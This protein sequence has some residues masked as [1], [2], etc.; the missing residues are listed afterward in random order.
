MIRFNCPNCSQKFKVPEDRAGKKGKCPKCKNSILIPDSQIVADLLVPGPAADIQKAPE[1]SPY[2]LTFL[3]TPQKAETKTEVPEPYADPDTAEQD[4]S[5]LLLGYGRS[6]AEPPAERKYPW[7]IDIL[8][9]PVSVSSLTII[10]ITVVLPLLLHLLASFLRIFT[11]TFP[12]GAVFLVL[13]QITRFLAGLVLF[14]YIWWYLCEC[15]TDSATGGLRAPE[16]A[17]KTPGF[18]EL[19]FATLRIVGCILFFLAPAVFYLGYFRRYDTTLWVLYGCG[20]FFFPMGLL[21]VVMF[22]SIRAVNPLLIIGS[23]FSTFF[24]YIG[25]V[26]FYYIPVLAIPAIIYFFGHNFFVGH[27]AKLVGV[28]LGMV[29]AHL[30][31]RFFFRYEEKL[32]WEV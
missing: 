24:Q 13:V 17:G 18:E 32:N 29:T 9:Y 16:T 27:L 12:P 6:E 20:A 8:L 25:L 11:M 7:P 14:F 26:L 23:I 3:D 4:Q 5:M 2:N 10:A 19:F 21:A 30:L 15:L 22:D 31:G 28:Y 1:I